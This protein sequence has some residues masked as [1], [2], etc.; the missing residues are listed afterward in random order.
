MNQIVMAIKKE[1]VSTYLTV[2][3]SRTESS[4]ACNEMR[5]RDEELW[6]P[7]YTAKTYTIPKKTLKR[8]LTY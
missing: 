1:N 7:V 4:T 3:G 6:D 5:L 8:C 2:F